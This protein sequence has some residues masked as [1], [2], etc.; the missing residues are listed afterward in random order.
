[1]TTEK[2]QEFSFGVQLDVGSRGEEIFGTRYA[3]R[4]THTDGVAG[5][6]LWK[7]TGELVEVK[8]DTYTG[9]PNFFMERW[10]DYGDRKPG[11]PWQAASKGV[12]YYAYLFPEEGT[13]D[14]PVHI[15]WFKISTL[16]TYL[17]DYIERRKL[18]YITVRNKAWTTVGYKVP[19]KDIL[20]LE[21]R[22]Y[23]R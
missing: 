13:D 5:D 6:F 14:A 4:V 2:K 18:G 16:C 19:R 3:D 1:M 17:E 23:E 21:V 8:T 22:P 12:T 7:P 10:S 11:G 15:Y 9:S 20:H